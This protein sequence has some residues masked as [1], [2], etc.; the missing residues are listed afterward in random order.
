MCAGQLA[1]PLYS[2]SGVNRYTGSNISRRRSETSIHRDVAVR[3]GCSRSG[4]VLS[5]IPLRRSLP[6]G[7]KGEPAI[8]PCEGGG[9][10]WQ[11]A[12]QNPR[13]VHLRDEVWRR[14]RRRPLPLRWD[15]GVSYRRA[16]LWTFGPGTSGTAVSRSCLRTLR[17]PSLSCAGWPAFSQL[18]PAGHSR[19]SAFA[20]VGDAPAVQSLAYLLEA[21]ATE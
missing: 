12:L 3:G 21:V 14:P 9:G 7:R 17:L 8:S 11:T 4:P 20:P 10:P 2:R 1:R 6:R 16:V 15:A 5:L 18:S 19:I 13:A